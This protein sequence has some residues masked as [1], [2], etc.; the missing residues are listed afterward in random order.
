MDN[1]LEEFAKILK[2]DP[3]LAESFKRRVELDEFKE[4]YNTVRASPLKCPACSQWG[5]TG[6]SLWINKDDPSRFVCR[7]CKLEWH[8]ECLTL[9]TQ[10]LIYKMKQIQKG[11]PTSGEENKTVHNTNSSRR[12]KD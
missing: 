6:G 1:Q 7:K 9:P 12:N 5:Q 2:E 3:K 8:V 11:E 4:K 10:D